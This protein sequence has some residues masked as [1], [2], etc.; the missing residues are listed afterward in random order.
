MPS[1]LDSEPSLFS[2]I[3]PGLTPAHSTEQ[4]FSKYLL[5]V[6]MN[7]ATGAIVCL[8]KTSLGNSARGAT[9]L[10]GSREQGSRYSSGHNCLKCPCPCTPLCC[11]VIHNRMHLPRHG[12]SSWVD[13]KA[14][15]KSLL[16][17]KHFATG[18][19]FWQT[20]STLPPD[21]FNVYM[22]WEYTMNSLRIIS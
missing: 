1:V 19:V 10:A 6:W 5:N 12:N 15:T 18:M 17:K 7:E 4:V 9:E 20:Q 8:K 16:I 13:R 14:D 21:G 3:C 22:C 2:P 11:S